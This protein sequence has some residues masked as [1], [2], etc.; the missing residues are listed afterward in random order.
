MKA[1]QKAVN[2]FFVLAILFSLRAYSQTI[3][4]SPAPFE[5]SSFDNIKVIGQDDDGIF[6]LESN[7]P[8]ELD[9]DHV[10][11][12]NRKYKVAYYSNE[13]MQRWAKIIEAMPDGS[14]IQS[15]LFA[16]QKILIVC[17]IDNKSQNKFSFY[18]QWMNNKG[19]IVANKEIGNT[20]IVSS[21]NFEKAK[22]VTSANQQLTGVIIHEY[23]EDHKQTLHLLVMDSMLRLLF[24]KNLVINY[25]VK[26]FI[27]TDY[28]LSNNGDFHLLGVRTIK[29]K[30]AAK[31]KQE[32][33]VLFS[34]PVDSSHFSD[35]VLG[36]KGKDVTNASMNFDNINNKIVCAG[37]YAD[38]SA[39]TGAGIIYAALEMNNPSQLIVKEN[40]VE[41]GTRVQLA[42]ERN[43]ESDLGLTDYP[44]EKIILRNDGG[45]VLV[46]EAS[47]TNDYSYYD[48]FTQSFTRR[49]EFHYN[50]IVVISVNANGTI[51]WLNIVRKNQESEDD[52]GSFSSFCPVLTP[53]ELILI[54]NNEISRNATTLGARISNTGVQSENHLTRPADHLL[55][56]SRDGKQISENEV[57]IP[58]I[59]KK[60]MTLV[61]ITY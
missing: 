13:L 49:T 16:Q 34:A 58:C 40:P 29:D 20:L 11:F 44:I 57:V 25:D 47:Y 7:L 24:N 51:A 41:S 56:F 6:L 15:V 2:L 55:L 32:D 14:N 5:E 37:F 22:L 9:R 8:F 48:Y 39:S 30:N 36:D 59:S 19:E 42:G 26:N 53:D 35:F 12:K 23:M 52:G 3:M 60:K 54:Y 28:S 18:A 50:N 43:R 45:A 61:K 46:A 17:A 4:I 1:I 33:F 38:R 21:S 10:G 27:P 31:K